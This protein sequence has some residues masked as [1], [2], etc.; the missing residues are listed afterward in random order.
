MNAGFVRVMDDAATEIHFFV[1]AFPAFSAD[2]FPLLVVLRLHL[3]VVP[4]SN[5]G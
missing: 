2:C 4:H 3:P 5:L 1:A